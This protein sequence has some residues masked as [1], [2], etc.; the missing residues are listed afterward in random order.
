RRACR[1]QRLG[2]KPLLADLQRHVGERAAD[3]ETEPN[4]SQ[5]NHDL[6]PGAPFLADSSIR[7]KRTRKA[8]EGDSS[9]LLQDRW[10]LARPTNYRVWP[11]TFPQVQAVP[12]GGARS[13]GASQ[14]P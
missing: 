6:G 8:K 2:R 3:V 13:N 10:L 9:R 7:G 12:G 11:V 5:R 1:R 14:V 4:C